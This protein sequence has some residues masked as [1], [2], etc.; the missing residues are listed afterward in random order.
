MYREI[1]AKPIILIATSIFFGILA[2][3]IFAIAS[4]DG[5]PPTLGLPEEKDFEN[6]QQPESCENSNEISET[7]CY[8]KFALQ[9]NDPSMCLRSSWPYGDY[10]AECIS[11]VA[12]KNND[13]SLC[14]WINKIN[15]PGKVAGANYYEN[16]VSSI[17]Q[18]TR[19]THLCDNLTDENRVKFCYKGV[20]EK[21]KNPL[22]CSK[23]YEPNLCYEQL[24]F[25]INYYLTNPIYFTDW[26]KIL[27][28]AYVWFVYLA[29]SVLSYTIQ[30]LRKFSGLYRFRFLAI[31]GLIPLLLLPW[32]ITHPGGGHPPVGIIII[33]LFLII[34]FIGAIM[35][36][37]P[38]K[39]EF[40]A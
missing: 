2:T 13:L 40:A 7:W 37:F 12:I 29:F 3:I 11:K 16:C 1:L 22:L 21:E 17:A 39:K 32:V 18:E 5:F 24:G 33:P 20:A 31:F 23:A 30:A 4:Y 19:D 28:L 8:T 14:D 25:D 26:T 9:Y 38:K 35:V 10:Q 36:W 15:T 6:V 27:G 34:G